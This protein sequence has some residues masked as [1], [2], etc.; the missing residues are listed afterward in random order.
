MTYIQ[1]STGAQ[2]A[3]LGIWTRLRSLL[4]AAR[5]RRSGS[6]RVILDLTPAQRKDVGLTSAMP[7][8]PSADIDLLTIVHLTAQR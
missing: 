4:R 6:R 5:R 1:L 7:C 2:S 3:A 8:C